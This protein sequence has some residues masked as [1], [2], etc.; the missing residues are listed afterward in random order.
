[1]QLSELGNIGMDY[2]DEDLNNSSGLEIAEPQPSTLTN[3]IINP[4]TLVSNSDRTGKQHAVVCGSDVTDDVNKCDVIN[5]QRHEVVAGMRDDVIDDASSPSKETGTNSHVSNLSGLREKSET[6]SMGS[7]GRL[8]R[9]GVMEDNWGSKKENIDLNHD[10]GY[11]AEEALLKRATAAIR[12]ADKLVLET[13]MEQGRIPRKT[14][15]STGFLNWSRVAGSSQWHPIDMSTPLVSGEFT[16]APLVLKTADSFVP[17][18]HFSEQD[19][20]NNLLSSFANSRLDQVPRS[21]GPAVSQDSGLGTIFSSETCS[22]NQARTMGLE[23]RT[24]RCLGNLSMI[25]HC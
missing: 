23:A 15:A 16:K 25:I 10:P 6:D 17:G 8:G 11:R 3:S 1:M 14:G 21:F 18:R 2:E 5:H 12:R 22:R 13:S 9:R 20:Y 19:S 4:T 7:D 24:R